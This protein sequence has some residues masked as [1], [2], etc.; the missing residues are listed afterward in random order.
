MVRTNVVCPNDIEMAQVYNL[1]LKNSKYWDRSDYLCFITRGTC[2]HKC[3]AVIINIIFWIV[4]MIYCCIY[5]NVKQ[6]NVY[7]ANLYSDPLFK[8]HVCYLLFDD[9]ITKI[10]NG[11]CPFSNKL[12][13]TI[14][15]YIHSFNI[16]DDI[17]H[18]L[19]VKNETYQFSNKHLIRTS[20]STVIIYYSGSSNSK[21]ERKT[22]FCS[23][24][25]D[26]T[27]TARVFAEMTKNTEFLYNNCGEE[28]IMWQQHPHE[29]NFKLY[30]IL[31][32]VANVVFIIDSFIMFPFSIFICYTFD[33]FDNKISLGVDVNIQDSTNKKYMKYSVFTISI[34]TFLTL[35]M[36]ADFIYLLC[37][38]ERFV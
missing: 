8:K 22:K 11:I 19:Y 10:Y 13:G 36:I 38:F 2:I 9:K 16:D 34:S 17:G 7:F 33:E 12:E 14:Q 30:L 20:G 4:I 26:I 6:K 31:F 24:N 15:M 32:I 35:V 28:V 25:N 5:F 37:N 3:I 18:D 21:C 1:K 23:I 29:N 27:N